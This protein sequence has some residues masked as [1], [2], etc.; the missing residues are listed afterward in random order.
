MANELHAAQ[1]D[2]VHKAVMTSLTAH[3]WVAID[4]VAV[5]SKVYQT[6]VGPRTALAYV[7]DFGPS[8]GS[9]MLAGEYS[10]EGSNALGG[11]CVLIAKDCSPDAIGKLVAEFATAAETWIGWTYAMRLARSAAIEERTDRNVCRGYRV[12]A[13]ELEN[14][15]RRAR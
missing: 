1:L 6:A 11:C 9:F 8:A 13:G 7:K 2:S 10:S 5:S 3:G 12:L 4:S 15:I 14:A